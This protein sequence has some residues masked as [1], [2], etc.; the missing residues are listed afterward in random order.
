M[1][2][3]IKKIIQESA[4]HELI[5]TLLS[6]TLLLYGGRHPGIETTEDKQQ[7][8]TAVRKD[9]CYVRTST[10][11]MEERGEKEGRAV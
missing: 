10:P 2:A 4:T 8:N 5:F 9:T 3:K 11:N 7:E 6:M 1:S